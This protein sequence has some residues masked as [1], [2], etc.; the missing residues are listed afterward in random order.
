MAWC[1]TRSSAWVFA[2]F[3]TATP[4]PLLGAQQRQADNYYC[5]PPYEKLINRAIPMRRP[6]KA[7]IA[8]GR[9]GA[10]CKTIRHE[11]VVLQMRCERMELVFDEYPTW[12][13]PLGPN[14]FG[15][16]RFVNVVRTPIDRRTDKICVNF[17]NKSNRFNQGIRV[18]FQML[19]DPPK[20]K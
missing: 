6:A 3:L 11:D 4:L 9:S 20:A 7:Q 10:A 5:A 1:V 16:G 18:E 17:Q 15:G 12:F 8:P 2:L 14:C 13:C 19:D